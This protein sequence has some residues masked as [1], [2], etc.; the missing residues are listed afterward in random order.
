MFHIG[1][2]FFI[3][4][5]ILVISGMF[6]KNKHEQKWDEM[7][8]TGSFLVFVGCIL[9]VVQKLVSKNEEEQLSEYVERRLKRARDTESGLT[10]TASRS[11]CGSSHSKENG[12]SPLIAREEL[13]EPSLVTPNVSPSVS[14]EPILDKIVE[15][16][17]IDISFRKDDSYAAESQALIQP[18]GKK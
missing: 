9:I 2:I 10:L 15:E 7:I 5:L 4:G 3:L 1:L 18:K 8:G 12:K 6:S 16:T 11:G 17:E 13:P 14:A